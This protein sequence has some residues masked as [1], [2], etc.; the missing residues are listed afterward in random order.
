MA[1]A[2]DYDGTDISN[3]VKLSWDKPFDRKKAGTYYVTYSV[4]NDAG[5]VSSV[6]REV[7]ILEPVEVIL[8]RMEYG[9]SGKGK[10][11]DTV[12][13]TNVVAKADGFIDINV[14]SLT[15]GVVTVSL[16]NTI[17][18]VT[19][20][21]D[22]FSALGTKQ[23]PLSAGTYEIQVTFTTAN[24]NKEYGLNVKMPVTPDDVKRDYLDN[25]VP[26]WGEG[27]EVA[28][29][30][31]DWP[32]PLP[33]WMEPLKGTNEIAEVNEVIEVNEIEIDD[34]IEENETPLGNLD[35]GNPDTKYSPRTKDNIFLYMIYPGLIMIAVKT[36]YFIKKKT[37][38]K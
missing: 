38:I 35:F 31:P 27:A 15:A 33:F 18:K 2:V 9:F 29:R 22:R 37:V 24:G 10:Q 4:T 20:I 30:D 7:R 17:S 36:V 21:T 8:R 19:V 11:G 26:L 3:R 23:F 16:I 13:H 5:L 25:E 12:K 14:T 6:R 28:K 32:R 34:V 1:K